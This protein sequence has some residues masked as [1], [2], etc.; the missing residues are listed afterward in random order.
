M[1]LQKK[2]FLSLIAIVLTG[3]AYIYLNY[4]WH[5]P[6]SRHYE[7][8]MIK[9][10]ESF[11][12]KR[13]TLATF[14]L[15]SVMDFNWYKVLYLGPYLSLSEATLKCNFNFYDKLRNA[16]IHSNENYSALLFLNE[17]N[18]IVKF[19]QFK[20]LPINGFGSINLNYP[21]GAKKEDALFQLWKFK[22]ET[23]FRI[24]LIKG[25]N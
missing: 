12:S 7:V 4:C 19:L 15:D 6:G 23:F 16:D 3:I 22:K 11:A 9:S 25:K 24:K 1:S 8:K 2:V 21:C 14:R 5:Y 10:L 20:G 18:K 13:D 17:K